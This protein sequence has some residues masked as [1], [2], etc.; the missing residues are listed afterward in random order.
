MTASFDWILTNNNTTHDGTATVP[1][2]GR[3][4][5]TSDAGE[6]ISVVGDFGDYTWKSANAG[7][8]GGYSFSFGTNGSLFL[9]GELDNNS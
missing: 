1:I 7:V 2:T 4:D 8:I 3:I 9:F 6:T 5:N